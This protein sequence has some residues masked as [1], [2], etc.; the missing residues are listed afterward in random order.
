MSLDT[1][2]IEARPER[3]TAHE[4][5]QRLEHERNSRLTQLQAIH[6]AGHGAEEQMMSAQKDTI[7]RVLNE[8]EAAFTRI[9]NGSYGICLGCSTHIPVERLEILPYTRFCVPCQRTTA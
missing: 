5:L 1:P 8:I 3:L 6:E 9:H 4:A 7:N 2:R